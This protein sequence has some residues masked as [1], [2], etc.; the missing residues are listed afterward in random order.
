M[1][2]WLLVLALLSGEVHAQTVTVLIAYYSRTGHTAAV[3]RAVAAGAANVPG[4]AVRCRPVSELKES[5]VRASD[6]V[7]VGSPVYNAGMA[8]EVKQFI[9]TWPLKD[10]KDKVGAAFCTA[11]GTTTG[12]ELTLMGILES[13]LVFQFVVVGGETWRSAFG[14]TAINPPA[15]SPPWPLLNATDTQRARA[16]GERV[17]KVTIWL[18]MGQRRAR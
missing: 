9:D 6:A 2:K 5:D 16:L 14:A 3:A 18:K 4:V 13:M 15:K 10:L 17:A 7:I 11:G 1:M 8:A 12:A